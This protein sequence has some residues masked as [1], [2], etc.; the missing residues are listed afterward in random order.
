MVQVVTQPKHALMKQYAYLFAMEDV[1]FHVTPPALQRI[2]AMALEKKT[3]AR[4]LRSILEY[5]LKESMYVVPDDEEVNAVVLD[6][7]AAGEGREGGKV[8][9]ELT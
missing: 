2:A 3:G 4:G 7:V 6:V 9:G 8:V 1:S 5:A